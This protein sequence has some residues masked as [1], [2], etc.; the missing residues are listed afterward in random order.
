MLS[1][2]FGGPPVPKTPK[3]L[4]QI[5]AVC[6]V[7]RGEEV[8]WRW[9]RAL[10][11]G[12]P[13]AGLVYRHEEPHRMPATYGPKGDPVQITPRYYEY[14]DILTMIDNFGETRTR[15]EAEIIDFL[16]DWAQGASIR[17]FYYPEI[18][19]GE[20][21][22]IAVF[23]CWKRSTNP[24]RHFVSLLESGEIDQND[25]DFENYY[26][27]F[28]L[29]NP[30]GLSIQYLLSTE[31]IAEVPRMDGTKKEDFND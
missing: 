25:E 15:V 13:P 21:Q 18:V 1:Q 30:V 17:F 9:E 23:K 5:G 16:H 24:H 14:Q 20:Q 10:I 2:V 26:E 31:E 29:V 27:L 22:Y 28:A 7:M 4:K 6:P 11:K 19:E 3:W 12:L 8:W